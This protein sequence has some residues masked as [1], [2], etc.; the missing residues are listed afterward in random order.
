MISF[1]AL[2]TA[3]LLGLLVTLAG[4]SAESG[5]ASG[6]DTT[7]RSKDTASAVTTGEQV[8][9]GPQHGPG[10]GGLEMMLVGT[11]LHDRTVNLS[12][13]QKATIEAAIAANKPAAAPAFDKTRVSALAAGIRSGKIDAAAVSAPQGPS[14]E[15]RAAH[16]AGAAKVLATLHSTLTPEQ[17]T[18]LVAAVTK[19]GEGHG[20]KGDRT[21]GEGPKGERSMHG[22]HAGPMGPMGGML[23]GLDLTQAQQDSIKTKLEA[24]R[25]AAPSE[26]DRAA[27]KSQHEAMRTAMQTKLQTFATDSF[28]A[29]AF[30]TPPAGAPAMKGPGAERFA[31]DLQIITS[32]L[33]PAQRE[34]LAAR[35][36][37]GPPARGTR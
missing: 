9:R 5:T 34:K 22:G 24:Q 19:H 31:T 28:D 35:I 3:S 33:E 11:A 1:R 26:A 8:N 7:A 12:A 36:E 32:V 6:A 20:P 37:A 18:A 13:E 17:R 25:P 16:Q 29:T 30:V 10:R 14:A 4:C 2:T 27:M 23:E 15:M 21:K